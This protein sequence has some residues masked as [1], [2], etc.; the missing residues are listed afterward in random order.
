MH[1]ITCYNTANISGVLAMSSFKKHYGLSTMSKSALADWQGWIT[2]ILILGSFGGALISAPFTDRLGRKI[3][4]GI[5]TAIFALSAILM[6]VNPGGSSGRV[7]FLVGRFLSGFG[8]GAASVVGTGYIAEIAPKAI[9]GGLTA[10]YNANTMLS[11]G[12]AYWINFGS[13]EHI[14]ASRNAQWQM[15]MGVQALPGVILLVGLFF[16]PESPRWLMSRGRLEEAQQ[17]LEILRGLPVDH[18]FVRREYEDIKSGVEQENAVHAGLKGVLSE[19]MTKSIR[20][21]LLMVMII[22][23]GF[24]FSGAIL[25]SI[26]LTHPTT[27][28]LFSGIYGC[29]KF[30]AVVVYCL[31]FI[32]RFGRRAG[33][34]GGT[35]LIIGSLIYLTVYLAVAHP[36]AN[37]TTGAAGWIAVVSIY[38]FALGYAVSWG[39]IPWIINAEVFP[40]KVRSTCMSFCIAWQYLVNF[41]LSRAQPNMA[42]AMHSWGPFLLFACATTVAAIYAY[43]AYP[44]TK[45]V[46]M[47]H[48]E[49]LFAMSWYKIGRASLGISNAQN[50][51]QARDVEDKLVEADL[52]N[53]DASVRKENV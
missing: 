25:T 20:K 47:E 26:G 9:R 14:E 17:L 39:T 40:Q 19:I 4:L 45:G 3:S 1:L 51:A 49:E 35:V 10:T 28:F 30:V 12:L 15:P 41:A 29:V 52:E 36:S 11:V 48:M 43:F 13:L 42:I 24:Q 33:L 2:S 31:Y 23:V 50:T 18:D 38:I 46:S 16:I 44:E 6:A 5:W 53:K 37:S 8:S 7:Q 22:Q 32:D 34:F 21:R 27:N